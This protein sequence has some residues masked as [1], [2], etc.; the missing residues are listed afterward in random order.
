MM[1]RTCR[2]TCARG[3]GRGRGRVAVARRSRRSRTCRRRS[4]SSSRCPRSSRG[5]PHGGAASRFLAR[6]GPGE[7]RSAVITRPGALRPRRDRGRDATRSSSAPA[8]RT[9]SGATG[10]RPPT[11]TP[12]TSAAPTSFSSAAAAGAR[13]GRS[14]TSTSRGRRARRSAADRRSRGG[15]LRLHLGAPTF[16]ATAEAAPRA[17]RSSLGEWGATGPRGGCRPRD[18]PRSARSRPASSTTR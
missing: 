13:G 9:A 15:Q 1:V 8:T 12:S 6:R 18:G 10:S 14:T 2:D 5:R 7:L 16:G 17:R 4:T 11:A 3:R